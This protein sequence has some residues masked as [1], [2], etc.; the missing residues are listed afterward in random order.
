MSRGILWAVL[1]QPIE[2]PPRYPNGQPHHITLFY[3]VERKDWAHWEGLEFEATLQQECW[4]DRVQALCVWM[5]SDIPCGNAHPHITVS[6]IDGAEAN[7]SNAMLAGVHRVQPLPDGTARSVRC[8]IEF[9]ERPDE[10]GD[11]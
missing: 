3:G 4:N 8:R 9:Q 5:R 7:E 6:W 10:V 1:Q 2:I 11:E